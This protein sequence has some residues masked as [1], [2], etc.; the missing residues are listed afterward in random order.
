M[1][2]IFIRIGFATFLQ[3]SAITH[4]MNPHLGTLINLDLPK[5]MSIN[6][7]AAAYFV[8]FKHLNI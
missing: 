1:D 8:R 7:G 5:Y 4:A 2:P 3:N 6:W